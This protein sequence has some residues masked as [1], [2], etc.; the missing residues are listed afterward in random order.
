[1]SIAVRFPS[2]LHVRAQEPMA[3]HTSLGVG[4][5]A[6]YWIEVRSLDALRLALERADHLGIPPNNHGARHEHARGRRRH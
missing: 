1:M 5:P 4:G 6:D 2:R 3:R